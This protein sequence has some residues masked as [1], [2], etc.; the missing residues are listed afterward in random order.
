MTQNSNPSTG[1]H[2]RPEPP[3]TAL[4]SRNSQF[5]VSA[6]SLR[7][8]GADFREMAECDG[9]TVIELPEHA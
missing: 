6:K 1:K 8:Q 2:R 5:S 9:L 3:L 4:Y 7:R